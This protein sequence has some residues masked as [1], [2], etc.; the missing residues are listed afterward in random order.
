[1]N[2][3]GALMH[4]AAAEALG[5]SLLHSLWQGAAVAVLLG[6]AFWQIRRDNPRLR[7]WLAVG[8]LGLLLAGFG[9]TYVREYAAADRQVVLRLTDTSGAYAGRTRAASVSR[10]ATVQQQ[11]QAMARQGI[12]WLSLAWLIG[13]GALSV[14]WAGG[15]W[16]LQ[17]TRYRHSR[18][19]GY[20]AQ[21]LLNRLARRMGIRQ[22][23]LIL[24]TMRI[25]AP[26][27][28]GHF[29]PVVLI[30]VGML[31]GLTPAQVEAI[32]AHE[33]AHISRH[34]YLINLLLTLVETLFFYHPA[35]WWLSA[36]IRDEREQCCDDVAVAVCGNPLGY[37]RA[38]A[39]LEQLRQ[40]SPQLA[41]G[42]LGR[43]HHLLYRIKRLL[44]PEMVVMESPRKPLLA[45]LLVAAL[46]GAAW[47]APEAPA[48]QAAVAARM[49]A[50][51]ADRAPLR[52]P[53]TSSD[54]AEP[55][56]NTPAADPARTLSPV[57]ALKEMV[58]S[59]LYT[60]QDT[61]PPPPPA[62]VAPAPPVPPMPPMPPMPG[63]PAPPAPPALPAP[64]APPVFWFKSGDSLSTKAYE[65][66]MRAWE[67][68]QE[69]WAEAYEKQWEAYGQAM[70]AWGE[71][72]AESWNDSSF[73]QNFEKNFQFEWDVEVPE[74]HL[75]YR[76]DE[77]R[78]LHRQRAE[79]MRER[80]GQMRQQQEEM[81]HQ[82]ETRVREQQYRIE[83]L[84]RAEQE[85]NEDM[86]RHTE[87]MRRHA[88][89]MRRHA[90]EMA[91]AEMYMRRDDARRLENHLTDALLEDGLIED[92][93]DHISIQYKGE[94]LEIN[95]KKIEGPDR[96][97]Y[98]RI[99]REAGIQLEGKTSLDIKMD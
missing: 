92:P 76:I 73:V 23:L 47:M 84:R 20:E 12:P 70:E 68:S 14:R 62:P 40:T 45:G 18:V 48:V 33:L 98:I 50:T 1:M 22:T 80:A 58:I 11:L 19:M 3:S 71:S 77:D 53:Q 57:Q 97:K 54:A 16:W 17:E 29:R 39:S 5:W 64:P 75:E 87:D 89:D 96:E 95:G 41:P 79:E 10:Q 7:Y 55:A 86:R 60:V 36:R 94:R 34:D 49:S 42:L 21:N 74:L 82:V 88:E 51:V 67:K 52:M 13:V 56:D 26:M 78:D 31:A 24:E 38:L 27:V 91:R 25:Q 37:A 4:T 15:L 99:L 8:G 81:R 30:P 90:E 72:F 59:W 35:V 28:M 2:L 44:T 32:L 46:V 9:V 6:L 66:Q 43:K 65:D 93:D 83:E 63:M 85:R 61:P 69:A